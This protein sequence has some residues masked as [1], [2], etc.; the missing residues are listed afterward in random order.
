MS[1]TL[2]NIVPI[3]MARCVAL[4]LLVCAWLWQDAYQGAE[5]YAYGYGKTPV[6]MPT[7]LRKVM[8]RRL[9]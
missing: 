6:M 4:C 8:E 1:L 2:P 3:D 9:S 7:N 5:Y